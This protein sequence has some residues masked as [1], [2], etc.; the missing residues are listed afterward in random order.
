MLINYSQDL[1][2]YRNY[3]EKY[4][5][6]KSHLIV[7]KETDAPVFVSIIIPTYKRPNLLKDAIQ[8]AINQKGFDDYEII[9]VDND[10]EQS[11]KTETQLLVERIQHPKI[12]YYKH[13]ENIGMFPN[14]NRG[15][16]LA[17]GEWITFLH[18]D[19]AYFSYYLSAMVDII[20]KDPKIEGLKGKQYSWKD[21]QSQNILDVEKKMRFKSRKIHIRKVR[22][23]DNFFENAIGPTGIFYKK[24]NMIYLGG[25]SQDFYPSADYLMGSRYLYYFNTFLT[26]EF[27]GVYRWAENES[28]KLN[29]QVLMTKQDYFHREQY[30]KLIGLN[31]PFWVNVN[32][33][34]VQLKINKFLSPKDN[35]IGKTLTAINQK[36]IKYK[37]IIKMLY[38]AYRI[39]LTLRDRSF[40]KRLTNKFKLDY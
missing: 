24:S 18:D 12:K 8:S 9:I 7:G 37:L 25:Y 27:L 14:F 40:L 23:Y 11:F 39:D 13:D 32:L 17:C 33:Y 21:D 6:I 35:N 26:F 29:T 20:K 30:T 2:S 15:I 16:E 28:L 22:K 38:R 5:H 4:S 31:S 3:F 34:L 19:D 36:K 10:P 1:F